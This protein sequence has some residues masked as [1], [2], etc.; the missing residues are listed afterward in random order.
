MENIFAESQTE[1]T[2]KHLNKI[3]KYLGKN[4]KRVGKYKNILQMFCFYHNLYVLAFTCFSHYVVA[5][6]GQHLEKLLV[7]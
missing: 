1:V 3:A 4:W 5:M 2:E 7:R 6:L